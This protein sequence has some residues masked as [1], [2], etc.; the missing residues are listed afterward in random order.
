[1]VFTVHLGLS[2]TQIIS[3][4]SRGPLQGLQMKSNTRGVYEKIIILVN[5][6]SIRDL[7]DYFR[8]SQKILEI[9]CKN[10]V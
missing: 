2:V 10:L 4:I 7:L 3:T 8:I 1:M 9:V 6:T 5:H